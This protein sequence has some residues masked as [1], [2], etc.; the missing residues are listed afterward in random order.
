MNTHDHDNDALPG[1]DE[2]KALYRSLPR[3][4]PSPELDRAIKRAAAD[5]VR[6]KPR[7]SVPR[8]PVAVASAAMVVVAAGLGWR[9]MQQ[10]SNVPQIQTTNSAPA[11]TTPVPAAAPTPPPP[12]PAA[13]EDVATESATPPA[14]KLARQATP[15][16][17]SKQENIRSAMKPKVLARVTPPPSPAPAAPPPAVAEASIAPAP[18]ESANVAYAPVPVAAPPPAPPA[19]PA[20]PAQ[21]QAAPAEAAAPQADVAASGAPHAAMNRQA[22][23]MRAMAAPAPIV[24]AQDVTAANSADTPTQELGKIRQLFALQRRD[25]A[26]QR[27]LAFRKAHPDI[28]LPDDLRAQL[29]DHE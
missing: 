18:Q 22:A 12:P 4:E 29:P 24:P 28:A 20:A 9:L 7:H 14:A 27:L 15:P 23:A 5:A 16:L 17:L 25:E 10:P 3:K 2:L 1:D 13:T 6:S 19:P 8:W 21:M 26:V 11:E